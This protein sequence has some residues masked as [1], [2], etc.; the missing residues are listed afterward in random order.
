MTLSESKWACQDDSLAVPTPQETVHASNGAKTEVTVSKSAP[1]VSR[2][3]TVGQTTNDIPTPPASA[4]N[5]NSKTPGIENPLDN[6]LSGLSLQDRNDSNSEAKLLNF[7]SSKKA[8]HPRDKLDGAHINSPRP[9]KSS[10]KDSSHHDSNGK[11]HRMHDNIGDHKQKEASHGKSSPVETKKHGS[12]KGPMTAGARALAMR[13]GVPDKK[14]D[15]KS[16]RLSTHARTA[17]GQNHNHSHNLKQEFGRK[18]KA[19]PISSPSKREIDDVDE[20][21]KAEV[22]AMFEK[23]SDKSTSWA[24]IE[25]WADVE[26]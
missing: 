21:I 7:D 16:A 18:H 3:A 5:K 24:D 14:D 10:T 19:A 12:D 17:H 9:K 20:T 6:K 23:M 13:I 22:Q 26:D 8:N 25:D 2:W 15:F 11:P 1:L 4:G